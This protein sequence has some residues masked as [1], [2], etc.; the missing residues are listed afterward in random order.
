MDHKRSFRSL[1]IK[2]SCCTSTRS[3]LPEGGGVVHGFLKNLRLLSWNILAGLWEQ[4]W[5]SGAFLDV[6][7]KKV[8]CANVYTIGIS[9]G[10]FDHSNIAACP[11]LTIF[12]HID[13]KTSHTSNL[14]NFFA[15]PHVPWLLMCFSTFEALWGGYLFDHIE[16]QRNSL[17]PQSASRY[18]SYDDLPEYKCSSWTCYVTVCSVYGVLVGLQPNRSLDAMRKTPHKKQDKTKTTHQ[19]R[20][21]KTQRA[22]YRT[23]QHIYTGMLSPAC[24]VC[25]LFNNHYGTVVPAFVAKRQKSGRHGNLRLPPTDD[26]GFQPKGW[27]KHRLNGQ[28]V[29]QNRPC[30]HGLIETVMVVWRLA[31]FARIPLWSSKSNE[32][33]GDLRY[34]NEKRMYKQTCKILHCEIFGHCY[35]LSQRAGNFSL[36]FESLRFLFL[37]FW[38]VCEKWFEN[39]EPCL[40]ICEKRVPGWLESQTVV[41]WQALMTHRFE[42]SFWLR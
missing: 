27:L 13:Q 38:Q 21:N 35:N 1:V 26:S 28:Q 24:L 42:W 25:W 3:L 19:A 31:H 15:I 5:E 4:A 10:V 22:R 6:I 40:P 12:A 41:R 11:L 20:H 14:V 29:F 7:A 2:R 39:P 8:L 23:P 32:F 36:R 33:V 18:D 17:S 9:I 16:H 34:G 30:G 37:K